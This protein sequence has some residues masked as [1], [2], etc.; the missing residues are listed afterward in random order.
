VHAVNLAGPRLGDSAVVVGSGMIGLL[1]IQ[2]LRNAGCGR[3]IAGDLEDAKLEKAR[4]MGADHVVNARAFSVPDAV[5][6]LTEGRGADIAMEAVGAT[7][8]IQA[9]VYSVRKGGTVVLIGNVTPS[10]ELPLQPVVTRQIRVQGSCASNQDYPACIEL[11]ARGAIRVDSLISARARL[12]ET[13]GW[14]DRLYAGDP[15]VM[16]V[17]VQP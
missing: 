12:E 5:K 11:M 1:T 16:K 7:D 2:A 9:A 13:A 14:F 4:E 17:I 10:I 3:I 6:E 8:P 15:S